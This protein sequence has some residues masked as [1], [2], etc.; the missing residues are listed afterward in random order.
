MT[1]ALELRNVSKHY[2]KFD[3]QNIDLTLPRGCIMGLIGENGAGKSTVLKLILN[4][5]KRDSGEI[6]VLDVPA[7]VFSA[8]RNARIG[9]VMD[10]CNIPDMFHVKQV[11]SVMG[12][13]YP[14][15][16]S[17]K[18]F[19]L[20]QQFGLPEDS[21]VKSFSRGMKMKLSIAIAMSH[22]AELLILDE[23]TSGLDPV[24]RDEILDLFQDFIQDENHAVLMASHITSDLEKVCDYI[25]YI[26]KGRIEISMEKD[27][28]LEE[29]AVFKGAEEQ[30][31]AIPE[32]ALIRVCR[33]TYGVEALV[34]RELVNPAFT[35]ERPTLESI[36]LFFNKGEMMN[37]GESR[38]GGDRA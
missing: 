27:R 29:Y 4:L 15:W 30:L 16:D 36:M 3:L 28:L 6:D 20:I 19:S 23:A 22:H 11:D 25:T 18:F 2:D 24:V 26:T 12:D 8:E 9:V 35:L 32:D 13:L 17:K 10:E 33:N 38:K 31:Q 5:I 21:K 14:N 1:H 34:H 7:E 37:K